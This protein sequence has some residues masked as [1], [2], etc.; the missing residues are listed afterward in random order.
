[1]SPQVREWKLYGECRT[2]DLVVFFR[3]FLEGTNLP[4]GV[5]FRYVSGLVF[6]TDLNGHGAEATKGEANRSDR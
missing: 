4:V 6:V 2:D 3:G 1:V 5:H